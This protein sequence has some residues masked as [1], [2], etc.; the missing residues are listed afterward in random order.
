MTQCSEHNTNDRLSKETHCDPWDHCEFKLHVSSPGWNILTIASESNIS[1]HIVE[2]CL[3]L[4]NRR[5]GKWLGNGNLGENPEASCSECFSTLNTLSE[6]LLSSFTNLRFDTCFE[7]GPISLNWWT[8][9]GIWS[10]T[11]EYPVTFYTIICKFLQRCLPL[12]EIQSLL[13]ET[14]FLLFEIAVLL[15]EIKFLLSDLGREKV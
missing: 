10:Q 4:V 5:T 13:F 8:T 15:F 14:K 12:F 1:L 7:D 6:E 9:V 2:E 11:Q 3:Q